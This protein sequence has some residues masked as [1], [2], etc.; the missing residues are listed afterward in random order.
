MSWLA[1]KEKGDFDNLFALR[2]NLYQ[3]YRKFAELFWRMSE[4]E[5]GRYFGNERVQWFNGGVFDGAEVLPPIASTAAA[6]VRFGAG[7]S[8]RETTAETTAS[9]S[10]PRGATAS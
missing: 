3:D 2:P 10:W 7:T 1:Q 4:R 6:S 9:I 5:A 8:G